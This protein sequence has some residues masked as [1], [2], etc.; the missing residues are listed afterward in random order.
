MRS[1]QSCT[2]RHTSIAL[3]EEC[4]PVLTTSA[5]ATR[6]HDN[7]MMRENHKYEWLIQ[8]RK[9]ANTQAAFK[10]PMVTFWIS[11]SHVEDT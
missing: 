1:T 11:K 8:A 9:P 10:L 6:N 2:A 7:G 5:S 4:K 3:S